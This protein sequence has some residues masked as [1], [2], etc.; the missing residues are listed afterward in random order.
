MTTPYGVRRLRPLGVGE[1][2]DA[3]FKLYFGNFVTMAKAVLFIA[4]PAGIIEGLTRSAALPTR[5]DGLIVHTASTDTIIGSDLVNELVALLASA[6]ATAAIFQVIASAY[7]GNPVTW[8]QALRTGLVRFRSVLWIQLLI[9]VVVIVPPILFVLL[10]AAAAHS[11]HGAA[12]ALLLLIP[13]VL[14]CIWFWVSTSLAVPL[15]MLENV[16][17]WAAMRRAI[18]LVRSAWWSV[19]GT[20]FLAALLVGLAGIF[21]ELLF[22][23]GT[24]AAHGDSTTLTLIYVVESAVTSTVLSPF[25]AAVLIV[26]TIDA[27]VRKE[28]FDIDLLASQMGRS[29]GPSAL[30]FMRPGAAPGWYPG[31]GPYAPSPG[32]YPPPPPRPAGPWGQQG[33]PPG[34]QGA[35]P[36]APAGQRPPGA[37]PPLPQGYPPPPPANPAS[38]GYPPPTP[39]SPPS[40][41][42]PPPFSPVPSTYPPPPVGAPPPYPQPPV[43]QPQAPYPQ[44]QYPQ[45]PVAPYPSPPVA[46][47][48]GSPGAPYPGSPGTPPPPAPPRWSAGAIR[49]VETEAPLPPFRPP[50]PPAPPEDPGSGPAAPGAGPPGPSGDDE[51]Q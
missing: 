23:A 16:R 26:L 51:P 24:V 4:V 32:G 41:Y 1:R 19:F 20:E 18:G 35:W 2:L 22:L 5:I 3:G 30:S 31:P 10:I 43:G 33:Y 11:G 44:P 7:L 50:R 40:G 49:P 15:L 47:Y 45:P 6:I 39:G 38:P 13:W 34:Q 46:P 21:V 29:P 27:K 37:Y 17:G 25:T 28:G 8:R 42:P 12:A 48:P 14:F 36:P 9:Y